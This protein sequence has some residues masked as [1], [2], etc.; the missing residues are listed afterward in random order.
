M[1]I[2][3]S[4]PTSRSETP[5]SPEMMEQREGMLRKAILTIQNDTNLS[6]SEKA[7]E[8]QLLM[9]SNWKGRA[10]PAAISVKSSGANSEVSLKE[11]S[12]DSRLEAPTSPAMQSNVREYH[13]THPYFR[14]QKKVS[15]AVDIINEDAD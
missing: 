14:I 3:L 9:A 12:V 10:S 6:T 8:I 13:V 4:A 1:H 2:S 11:R 15:L 7:K 5:L